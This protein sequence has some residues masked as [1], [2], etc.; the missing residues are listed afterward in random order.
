MP[1]NLY[2]HAGKVGVKNIFRRATGRKIRPL[3]YT[4]HYE[5]FYKELLHFVDCISDDKEP[6]VTAI[7]GLKTVELIH[8]AYR[9]KDVCSGGLN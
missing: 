2:L 4:Y 9:L 7:D 3:Y 8:E 5:S 1:R 6:S